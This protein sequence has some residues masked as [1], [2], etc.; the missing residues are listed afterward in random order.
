MCVAGVRVW[1]VCC[2]CFECCVMVHVFHVHRNSF[3]HHPYREILIYSHTN[4][5]NNTNDCE[6][7]VANWSVRNEFKIDYTSECLR[8]DIILDMSLSWCSP[9][10]R[11]GHIHRHTQT[12]AQDTGTEFESREIRQKKTPKL[13]SARSLS[14]FLAVFYTVR[15]TEA[16][17]KEHK[18]LLSIGFVIYARCGVC[19]LI[20]V[21][22]SP[23]PYVSEKIKSLSLLVLNSHIHIYMK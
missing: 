18:M 17:H 4:N 21:F 7:I 23:S 10:P 11:P 13:E 16:N 15:A 19:R 20:W 5:E 22:P 8:V 6:W 14:L 2:M 3:Q 12:L 9:L 1:C